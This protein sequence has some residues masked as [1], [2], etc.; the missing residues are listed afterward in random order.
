MSTESISL[1]DVRF[2]APRGSLFRLSEFFTGICEEA[3]VHSVDMKEAGRKLM[4]ALCSK[5]KSVSELIPGELTKAEKNQLHKA[6]R[7]KESL[8]RDGLVRPEI[9]ASLKKEICQMSDGPIYSLSRDIARKLAPEGENYN[10]VSGIQDLVF[11]T[12]LT[13][14][15]YLS[16][17]EVRAAGAEKDS[18]A[19]LIRH[20]LIQ[21]HSNPDDPYYDPVVALNNFIQIQSYQPSR[22]L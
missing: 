2:Q 18:V 15:D 1:G 12:D 21:V 14:A 16:S 17:I 11:D 9:A 22:L 13:E 20:I 19:Q 6:W 3:K 10:F 7:F 8:F 5:D 4:R